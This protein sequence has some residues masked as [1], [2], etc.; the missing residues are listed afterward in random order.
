MSKRGKRRRRKERAQV[1]RLSE[2]REVEIRSS[3]KEL[4]AEKRARR[5]VEIKVSTKSISTGMYA[6]E[7]VSQIENEA[8]YKKQYRDIIWVKPT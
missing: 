7:G 2:G 4:R 3:R 8:D 6:S 5:M 1:R